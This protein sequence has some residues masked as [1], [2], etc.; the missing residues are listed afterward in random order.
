MRARMIIIYLAMCGI[1]LS[2][3]GGG[4][5]RTIGGRQAPKKGQIS[6]VE[7]RDELD[8]FEFLFIS[9]MKRVADDINAADGTRRARRTNTRMQTRTIEALHAMTTS[10]DP[11]IAFLDTWALLMRLELYYNGGPGSS[12]HGDQQHLAIEFVE[13]VLEYIERVGHLFLNDEQF[14]ELKRGVYR[15]AVQNPIDGRYSNLIVFATQERKEEVGVLMKTLSIP[16]APIRAMEGVDNTATAILR[17][18]D[19]IERFNDVA[20]QMPESM[21]WQMSILVDDFEESEMAQSFLKSVD[22]F[23]ESSNR[24][25]EVLDTMPEQMR[26]ELLTVLEESDQSQQ[27]LQTTLQ[28]AAEAAGRVEK[29]FTEL[30]TTSQALNVTAQQANDAAIAWREAS[31]SIQEL[32]GMF[33]GKPRD[34]NAPPGFGMRDFDNMLLNAGQTADKVGAAVAQIQ[35]TVDATEMQGELRSLVDHVMWRLFELVLAVVILVFGGRV[36]IKKL[37]D[38]AA[39]KNQ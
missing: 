16:M 13:K 39:K 21:R 30:N 9:Q 10:D 29:M 19:S 18:R 28:T 20:E 3:C 34:Q 11:V 6:K 14:E 12:I 17:V 5:K 7:L 37:Q 22:D 23:S 24:L 31:D 35:Q 26:T 33:K 25:V 15:F 32:V 4:T 36:L 38:V 1:V 2:G 27:Q 8:R